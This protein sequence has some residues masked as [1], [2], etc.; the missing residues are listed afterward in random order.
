MYTHFGTKGFWVMAA[1][2]VL[3]LPLAR[4]LHEPN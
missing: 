2:C 1:L 3:A 4:N